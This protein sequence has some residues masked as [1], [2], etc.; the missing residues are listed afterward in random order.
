MSRT[1]L[2]GVEAYSGIAAVDAYIG[3]T[4]P[5]RNPDIGFDYGGAHL[6]RRSSAR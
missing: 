3:A 4:Q 1:Y 6:L 5:H 2:N